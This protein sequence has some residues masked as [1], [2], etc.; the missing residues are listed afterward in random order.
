MENS[1]ELVGQMRLGEQVAR[2]MERLWRKSIEDVNRGVVREYA[3][4]LVEEQDGKLR[5][6]P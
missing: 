1:G 2:E 5:Y 6:V 3:A 4:T